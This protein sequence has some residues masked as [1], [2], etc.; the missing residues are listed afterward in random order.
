MLNMMTTTSVEEKADAHA[1]NDEY[2]GHD[3]DTEES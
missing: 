2:E 1:D 3:H